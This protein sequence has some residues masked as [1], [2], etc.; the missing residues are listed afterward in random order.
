MA[1]VVN[2]DRPVGCFKLY[3]WPGDPLGVWR[4]RAQESAQE[5]AKE[6]EVKEDANKTPDTQAIAK[7]NPD[8]RRKRQ[9]REVLKTLHN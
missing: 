6:D 9:K 3:K 7:D 2:R 5:Q 4:T 1:E 8:P